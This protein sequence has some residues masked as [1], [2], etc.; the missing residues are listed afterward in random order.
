MELSPSWDGLQSTERWRSSAAAGG[1]PT[2]AYG[3]ASQAPQGIVGQGSG[4]PKGSVIPEIHHPKS[5]EVVSAVP[6]VGVH[7]EVLP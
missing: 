5:Q 2:A 4:T 1:T 7:G 6:R 3:T